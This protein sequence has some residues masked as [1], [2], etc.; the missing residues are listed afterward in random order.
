MLSSIEY[1]GHKIS[2]KGIQPTE[3]KVR[4]IVKAPAPNNVTQLKAFLGMLNYYAKFLPNLSSKLTPLYR[5]LQKNTPWSWGEEQRQAFQQAKVALTS[6]KVLVHYDPSQKLIL[7][8]DASPYGVGAV[9]SHKLEDGTEHPVAFASRSLSPAEKYAQL[10][11]EGLAI[12]FGVRHFH[13]YLLGRRFTI[14]SDHKPLQYLFS[15]DKAIP[16]MASS[17]IQRWALTLS[18]YDYDIVFKPGSQ[19]ANADVLSRLPLPEHPTSVPFPQE[20]VLLMEVLQASPVTAKQIKTWTSHDPVLSKVRDRVLQGWVDTRDLSMQPYQ[21]R[22]HELSIEDGCVLWGNRIIVPPPGRAKVIDTLHEEHPGMARMKCL[23]RCYVWWPS[24]EQELEKKVK[25]CLQ[26]QMMQNS[27]PQIPTHPWEWP[28][29]PWA[30]L[31]I[32]YAGPFMG[33]M[34]LVAVDAHSK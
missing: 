17:R 26:C 12:V 22:K 24:M 30:R 33:K 11:K 2:E 31:H 4:A 6:A 7:S 9:L 3:E 27:P 29:R 16:T 18:A 20:T 8:C 10:D 13:H 15:E 21:R 23:A 19:H 28:Q 34:F 32:D 25:E 14:Y 1:L 5:L